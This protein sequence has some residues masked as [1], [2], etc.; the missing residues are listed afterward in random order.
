[1][2]LSREQPTATARTPARPHIATT[3][4]VPLATYRKRLEFRLKTAWTRIMME[5]FD[6]ASPIYSMIR[7]AKND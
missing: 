3:T 7:L 4:M 5:H 6:K 2:M 1:M